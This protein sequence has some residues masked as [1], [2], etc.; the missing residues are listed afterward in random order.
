M[1][2][3]VFELVGN[4]LP[5]DYFGTIRLDVKNNYSRFVLPHTLRLTTTAEELRGTALQKVPVTVTDIPLDPSAL[6]YLVI[7]TSQ[8]RDGGSEADQIPSGL[9]K[10]CDGYT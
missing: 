7:P 10:N 5:G 6:V 2:E 8:T 9:Y 4:L 3:N 1:L